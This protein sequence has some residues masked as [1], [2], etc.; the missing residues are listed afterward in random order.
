[1][2]HNHGVEIDASNVIID[3]HFGIEG[4]RR[5]LKKLRKKRGEIEK[6]QK[7]MAEI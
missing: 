5:R 6:Q 7:Q 2:D 1:M 4:T 3:G